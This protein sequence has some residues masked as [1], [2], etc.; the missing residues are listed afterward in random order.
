MLRYL[1][2]L[3]PL[4]FTACASKSVQTTETANYDQFLQGFIQKYNFPGASLAV[5][6]NGQIIHTSTAGYAD[7]EK[8]IAPTP[9]TVF[10]IASSSK[11]ITVIAVFQLLEK[12][13]TDIEASLN[14]TAFGPKGYLPEYKK[15]KD[16]RILKVTLRD[17][18]QHTGGWDSS[19]DNYDPQYDLYKISKKMHVKAPADA[20]SV[21]RYVLQYQNLDVDPGKEYHYS[22][23]G[24]NILARI[25]EKLSGETYEN[26]VSNHIL[27][28]LGIIDMKIAG[29]R[30]QDLLPNEARYYDDP[31]APL[32]VSQWDGKSK[33]PLAYNEFYFPTMDGHGGWLGTPS[34]LIKILHG[35]TPDLGGVQLLKPATVKVMTAPVANIG[36]PTAGLGWVVREGGKE[37]SHAGALE[38]GTLAYFVRR[39]DNSAWAVTFNRLPVKDISELGPIAQDMI[40]QMNA[41]MN[42]R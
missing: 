32:A 28:P 29:S 17:L 6:K 2:L 37:I 3:M 38:N 20:K 21:I 1:L 15:I 25:I 24:F 7:V 18:L 13:N 30:L 9:E 19:K 35:V 39:P 8:K 31:R 22:N 14:R 12:S 10:R 16:K 5:A 26:Y 23:F 40:E 42:K 41:E 4:A 36:N 27:K 34:D 11:P 33:G